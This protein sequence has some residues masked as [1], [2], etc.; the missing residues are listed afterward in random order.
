MVA[1]VGF[2]IALPSR[3]V[4]RLRR[5]RHALARSPFFVIRSPVFSHKRFAFACPVAVPEKICGLSL[6]LIFSTAATRALALHLP[7]AARKRTPPTSYARRI[8][9]K[10]CEFKS[11]PRNQ[12]GQEKSTPEGCFVL[13]GCGGGI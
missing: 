9:I 11:H 12:S 3:I 13:F 2:F 7:P 10:D 6:S 8:A 4:V 1:G 5:N